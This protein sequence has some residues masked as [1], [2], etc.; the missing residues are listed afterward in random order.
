M[1]LEALFCACL[2]A[3]QEGLLHDILADGEPQPK[4]HVF[5]KEIALAA[6]LAA[7]RED[8]RLR[9]A[10]RS[11]HGIVARFASLGC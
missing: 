6:E 9:G 10:D 4:V 1:V 11:T 3:W 2:S 8:G 7:V 5:G